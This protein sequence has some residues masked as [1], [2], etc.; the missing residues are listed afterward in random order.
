MHK[1]IQLF[2]EEEKSDFECICE[3][4]SYQ[5]TQPHYLMFY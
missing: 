4:F 5:K 1:N 2:C 3:K